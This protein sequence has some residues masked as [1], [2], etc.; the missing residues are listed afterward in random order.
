M[1]GGGG[2]SSYPFLSAVGLIVVLLLK[3]HSVGNLLYTQ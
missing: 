1:G 2:Q 3:H